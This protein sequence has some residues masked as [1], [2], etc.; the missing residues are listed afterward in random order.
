MAVVLEQM[1]K[2]LLKDKK[3]P[4]LVLDNK[5]HQL[6]TVEK[7]NR[8]IKKLESEMNQL[9]QKQGKL[10]NDLKDLKKL[11]SNL[12]QEIRD[13][14]DDPSKEKKQE[15]N[16]KL[17]VEINEKIE[18]N[19][20]ELL[21]MPK[22]LDAVNRQLMIETMNVFYS[23]LKKNEE[24]ITQI[25]DWVKV[26]R[27]QVKEK[28]VHKTTLEEYN[29]MVYGYLHDVLGGDVVDVFDLKYLKK[30]EEET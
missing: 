22:E 29:T 19:E 8:T 11:K 30:E 26:I 10:N 14:M 28:M 24:E 23:L 16:Q 5:W 9:L 17:V 12:L 3:I 13:N 2:D 20:D 6:F 15:Q 1:Y 25:I 7:K 21:D 27:E 4:Y 18:N